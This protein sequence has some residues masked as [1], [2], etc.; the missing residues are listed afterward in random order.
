MDLYQYLGKTRLR[1]KSADR[2]R[3]TRDGER[4][5]PVNISATVTQNETGSSRT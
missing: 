3:E 2:K 1:M 5:I 4:K